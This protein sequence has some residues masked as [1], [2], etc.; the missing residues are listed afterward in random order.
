MQFVL[1]WDY[2]IMPAESLVVLVRVPILLLVSAIA[3][4][5]VIPNH[6]AI[7]GTMDF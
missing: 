5:C 7:F 6:S 3:R 2:A 1:I 4:T